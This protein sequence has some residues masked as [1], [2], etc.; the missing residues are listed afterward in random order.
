MLNT[1]K[2]IED[3]IRT[4]KKAKPKRIL[5]Q[6][7]EGL[8]TKVQD[9][10]SAIEKQGTECVI[11]ADPTYGACDIPEKT[12]K[13]LECDLI[14]HI[15]HTNMVGKTNPK[16][17]YI[18][19]F[20]DTDM[21]TPLKKHAGKLKGIKTIALATTIQLVK[22]LPKIKEFLEKK[23][24]KVVIGKSKNLSY[25]GQILGCDP[26]AA[27]GENADAILYLGS[28]TFHPLGIARYTKTPIYVLDIE[29]NQLYDLKEERKLYEKK[30]ILKTIKYHDSKT[31]GILVS[32][33][34]AQFNK[35]TFKIKKQIESEGKKADILVMDNIAP[36][37]I[38]GMQFD[39][40]VN[41]ACPRIEDDLVYD[42]P[43]VNW[44]TIL[45]SK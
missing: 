9:I 6:V 26:T 40:L 12:A 34:K 8:K 38:T 5:L 16:T 11:Y 42:S 39:I 7:P 45:H 1:E 15:G 44:T 23:S 43:V 24:H 14:L 13:M 3:T 35:N 27:T 41:T 30:T 10:A 19:Y 37:K 22:K 29:K 20:A 28:G 4:V 18:E 2:I 17:E 25:A 32:T 33:K 36:D 31:V 21:L